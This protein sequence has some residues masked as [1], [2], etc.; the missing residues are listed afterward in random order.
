[1]ECFVLQFIL[2]ETI[3]KV[4]RAVWLNLKEALD[5]K[6]YKHSVSMFMKASCYLFLSLLF[7]KINVSYLF[8]T[9]YFFR[10]MKSTTLIG[11]SN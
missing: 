7:Y 2:I 4:V 9:G 11:A 8:S 5:M 6:Q 3:K 10:A 1:M